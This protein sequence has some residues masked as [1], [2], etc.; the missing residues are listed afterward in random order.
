MPDWLLVF[1]TVGMIVVLIGL[2]AAVR[3]MCST[4]VT[5]DYPGGVRFGGVK[6]PGGRTHYRIATWTANPSDRR[7][8]PFVL[9]LPGGD[10]GGN[11][12]GDWTATA[13]AD[14]LG[15]PPGL[16]VTMTH[17]DAGRAAYISVFMMLPSRPF[18]RGP[19]R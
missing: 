6:K 5:A 15:G 19:S 3:T 17:D 11:A 14:E 7:P 2:L 16:Y 4:H 18:G 1:V 9:H 12:L 13:R 10:L 8:C